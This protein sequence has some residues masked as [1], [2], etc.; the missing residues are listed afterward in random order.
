MN[1]CLL[2]HTQKY[3]LKDD[4]T[5]TGRISF[6]LLKGHDRLYQKIELPLFKGAIGREFFAKWTSEYSFLDSQYLTDA[7]A[8]DLVARDVFKSGSGA[9]SS[10]FYP[11]DNSI[12]MTDFDKL[13]SITIW[14]DRPQAGSVHDDKSIKLLIDRNI[15]SNDNGGI[16]ELL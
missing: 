11:I 14:N 16:P 2:K 5:E 15:K 3:G 4:K 8:Y 7:N 6:T 12:T 9:F 13:N 10:S 1:D